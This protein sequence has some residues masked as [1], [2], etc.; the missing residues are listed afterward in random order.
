[1]KEFFY[2][3]TVAVIGVSESPE[4]L[5]RN[6]VS[7]LIEFNF[8]GIIYEVGLRGGV[9]FGRRI[10]RSVSDIPDQIDLAVILTPAKTVPDILT[11]CGQK[12]IKHVVIES[13]G[14]REFGPEGVEIERRLLEIA[15]KYSIK[16]IGPNCI[17]I[18]NMK[19]GLVI[20]FTS[21]KNVFREG[22]ISIVTQS[23]G[24]GISYLNVL[25]SENLGLAKFVSIGNKLSIN[26]NDL[27]EYLIDD[28][29]TQIICVYLEGISDGRRLMEIARRSPKPILLHKSNIGKEAKAIAQS[30]TASLSSD[31]A[32]VSAALRQAG[33]ARFKDHE[34]LMNYLKILPLPRLKGSRLAIIS[35]SGGHAV[36]AADAAE[37]AGF[38]LAPF[39]EDFIRE[40]EKHFRAKVIKL[41]NPLDLGD[42]FDYQLYIKIVEQTVSQPDVDGVVFLHTYFSTTEGEA[43]RALFTELERI[44]FASNKPIAICVA[45]D[46]EELYRL[47]QKLPQPVF[48]SPSDAIYALALARD[49]QHGVKRTEPVLPKYKTDKGRAEKI[50]NACLKEKRDPLLGESFEILSAYG[51]PVIKSVCVEDENAAVR[52]A[53]LSGYPVAMKIVSPTI[54]HKTDLGGVQLNIR[55]EDALRHAFRDMIANIKK[56]VPGAPIEGVIVQPMIQGGRELIIGAKKDPNFGPAVMVGLGGI[57]VEIFRDTSLRIVPFAPEET[58]A[59]F[60]ELKGYPILKGARGEKGYDLETAKEVV[61]RLSLLIS[62]F[63]QISEIDLNPFRVMPVGEGGFCLDA[64]M[65]LAK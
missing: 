42:L 37:E 12:G 32:V 16:F 2:P 55:N 51:I 17:G 34:T 25:A 35:R 59:M 19:N 53:K 15:K 36:I 45:T 1:M 18:M 14:F 62:D 60:A 54:S 56:R 6:I 28:P 21:L 50:I 26:E 48:T 9:L 22:G 57:F 47:R 38:T 24:V 8:G 43:S 5:G 40:V 10:Y 63:P 7:N 11:E 39:N 31:D 46:E 3:K 13:A 61:G 44:S 64:R 4:N 29:E 30:H 49:F 23:G 52:E 58:D 20:P 65:I 33:I 41:T 27:L